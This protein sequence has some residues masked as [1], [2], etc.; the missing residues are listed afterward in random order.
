MLK[1][2]TNID[3]KYMDNNTQIMTYNLHAF[4]YN[5]FYADKHIQIINQLIYTELISSHQTL[6]KA[7]KPIHAFSKRYKILTQAQI[8][9]LT[10][11]VK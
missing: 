6:T 5:M 4:H 8:M 9:M 11:L 2:I 3:C 10:E 7:I 1:L